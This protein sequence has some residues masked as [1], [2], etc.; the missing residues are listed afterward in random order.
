[1]K[2]KIV[3]DGSCDLPPQLCL[4]KDIT[5]VPF[6]VS[7]D[8][9]TYE[10]EIVEIPIRTFY[11][12]MVADPTTFPKSSMPSVQDYVDV[13][14]PIVK[15]K[16]AVICICITTKF[17][18]SLQSAQ[19]AKELVKESIPDAEIT[20][21]DST[22]DTVLQGLYV[23]EAVELRDS[24]RSYGETAQRVKAS[25]R[26]KFWN[27][28]KGCLYDVLSAVQKSA[29]HGSSA[30]RNEAA[31]SGKQEASGNGPS[32]PDGQIRCNQIWAV[33][34]PF[35]MLE[36]E[37]EKRVVDVVF[38]KLYTPYGLRTLEK[39]DSQ[40]HGTYGGAQQ[41]R[42]LAY[43]QGTVWV[44]PLGAYYLAYLKTRGYSKEAACRV[45]SQLEVLE[46]AMREGCIGQL[47]EIY[48][49]ENPSFSRGCFAQAWSVGE[50]LRV[51]ELLE[52]LP[53]P[54]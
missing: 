41:Q 19:N 53:Q 43:H 30:G 49:G 2:Y 46:S 22:V 31:G 18:G 20:V 23:L 39:A 36:Q 47:P 11:E 8:S 10:K 15:E 7:F 27:Q 13:F 3:T 37:Q 21:I 34:M 54:E 40:F 48:D 4:E 45:K 16:T 42:D 6:Y 25:F 52:N 17:S 35:G 26:E 14:T 33:S 50:I 28:E 32:G 9:E 12:K 29:G 24:G 38:E 44:F 5:V 51:Y 1:M